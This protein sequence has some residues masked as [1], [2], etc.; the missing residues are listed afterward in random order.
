VFL[1]SGTKLLN[2]LLLMS[3]LHKNPSIM[4]YSIFIFLFVFILISCEKEPEPIVIEPEPQET[5]TSLK[6]VIDQ[7][8]VGCHTYGGNAADFGDFSNYPSIKTILDNSSQEFI[9]RISSTDPNYRMP[10]S[11]SLTNEQID[12]LIEWVNNDYPEN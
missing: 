2:N 12:K 8:C 4:K 3:K 9:N 11:G 10:P 7:N 6:T 1:L 5:Y